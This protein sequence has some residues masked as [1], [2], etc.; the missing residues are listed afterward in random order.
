MTNLKRPWSILHLESI[1]LSPTN[2]CNLQ[3]IMCPNSKMKIQRGYLDDNIFKKL[4]TEIKELL[5]NEL[6]SLK[7]LHFSY[8]GEPFMHPKY[9]E[10]LKYID[11]NIKGLKIFINT[12]ASLLNEELINDLLT[13]KNNHYYIIFSIDA[14][15]RELYE[16]IHVGGDFNKLQ[17]NLKYTLERKRDCNIK[18]PYTVLQFIVM[19]ENAH[20]QHAFYWKWEYLLGPDHKASDYTWWN[21]LN[22]SNCSHIYWKKLT[23]RWADFEITYTYENGNNQGSK[24]KSTCFHPDAPLRNGLVCAWPWKSICISYKGGVG[25]CWAHW[26]SSGLLGS[27][28]FES[29]QQIF[30]GEN[31]EKIR[32]LFWEKNYDDLPVCGNC[33]RRDWWFDSD[34]ELKL[35]QINL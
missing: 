27:L 24:S 9:I 6:S 8:D 28:K 3:C 12:N 31:A 10:M 5:L 4:I 26:E 33:D 14:S 35:E 18:N 17:K 2:H 7:E 15:Y 19:P 30:E 23:S 13:L 32:H 16:K 21:G 25:L 20:D 29:L 11:K 34:L 22:E 1:Y